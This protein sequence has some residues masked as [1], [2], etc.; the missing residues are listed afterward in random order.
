MR[1]IFLNLLVCLT[2][3]HLLGHAQTNYL[4]K[5][6]I[7]GRRDGL[8]LTMLMLVP[9][10]NANGKAIVYMVSG[11]WYSN[12]DWIPGYIQNAGPYLNRGYT[13]FLAMHRSRPM[14]NIEDGIEDAKRA[15][16]FVR[17][18]AADYK[19]SPNH[20]GI[21][22]ASSGGHLS[23]VVG[24][25]DDQM[26]PAS[27]DPVD[28][29]SGRVQAVACFFPPSD[30]LHWNNVTVDPKNKAVLDQADVY[31]AFQFREWDPVHK[32][33]PVI[34]DEEKLLVIYKKISPI[35]QISPDDPPILIA[36]GRADKIVPFS[37]S[38]HFIEKL[39]QAQVTCDF[40]IKDDGDHGGWKDE[41]RYE[42]AF[43]DWFDKYL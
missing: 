28:R 4:K 2:C 18:H 12:Y 34:T 13:I 32:N 23:L 19:I 21:T 11:G 9:G 35:N 17:Y 3:V 7:Y 27:K 29:V 25:D 14:F 42:N 33:Y 1:K 22:G 5:E 30:F 24:V 38:V 16:R 39:K 37:Q 26:D 41:V 6:L 36:H 8:A 40:L 10:S 20:I 43:A 31:S 15:V